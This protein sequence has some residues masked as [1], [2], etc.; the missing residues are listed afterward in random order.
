MWYPV[1]GSNNWL[2]NAFDDFFNTEGMPKMN[3]TAPAVNVK[4]SDKAYT[5]EVAAPGLKKEQCNVSIDK[6]GYLK[7]KIEAKEEKNE[8]R[9]ER[10]LH[11][12]FSYANYE[13]SYTLPDDVDHE[14]ISAKV[15]NGILYVELPKLQKKAPEVSRHIEIG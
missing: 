5:M 13:Q 2:S 10:Y 6:D 15:E 12:E 7:V 11:R 14:H 3:A 4:E 1:L 9:S 8:N